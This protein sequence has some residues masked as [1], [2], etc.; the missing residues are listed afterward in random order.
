MKFFLIGFVTKA[1]IETSKSG[2]EE[3]F[4]LLWYYSPSGLELDIAAL[5]QNTI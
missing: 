3:C 2:D 4:G 5:F 1:L